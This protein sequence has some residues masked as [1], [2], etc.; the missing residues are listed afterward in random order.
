MGIVFHNIIGI[1]DF[2]FTVKVNNLWRESGMYNYFKRSQIL[3]KKIIDLI[4]RPEYSQSLF[5]SSKINS[6]LDI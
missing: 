3:A 1:P 2:F 6:Y 5:D 4:I